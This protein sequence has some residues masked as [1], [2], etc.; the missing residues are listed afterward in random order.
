MPYYLINYHS[1]P[2]AS[3]NITVA[4]SKT[5]NGQFHPI[6][7]AAI[8]AAAAAVLLVGL[9][10]E[11]VGE[12]VGEGV[13]VVVAFICSRGTMTASRTCMRPLWVL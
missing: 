13:L 2:N 8:V 5:H 1:P 11:L 3:A 10:P 6:V 9:S 7:P 12:A 4:P